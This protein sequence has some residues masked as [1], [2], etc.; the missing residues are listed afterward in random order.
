MGQKIK[1]ILIMEIG[2][3]I[4][5]TWIYYFRNDIRTFKKYFHGNC[6]FVKKLDTK[7]YRLLAKCKHPKD[8]SI[9][10]LNEEIPNNAMKKKKDSYNYECWE[11][12]KNKQS[13]GR[14]STN[15]EGHKQN[16]TN[17]SCMFETKKYSHVE[18]KIFK[19]LDYMDFLKNSRTISNKTYRKLVRK[20]YG[21]RIVLP[22]LLFLLLLT[23]FVED[24]S[25]GY[26]F[27]S[28]GGS[29]GLIG[30]TEYLKTLTKQNIEW[31]NTFLEW[32]KDKL[33][34]LS[35]CSNLNT[36]TH[37]AC[38]LGPIFGILIYFIPF[39]ILGVTFVLAIFYYHK[40]VKKYEKIKYR[41]R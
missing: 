15:Q 30:L 16:I 18:K 40:K 17:K 24:L 21:L 14:S 29:W 27:E 10:G 7:T 22:L 11:K 34:W 35:A 6:N 1:F 12:S 37:K 19:E 32:L 20:K 8:T 5:L 41:K 26:A 33:P 25:V 3:F 31:L 4:L 9:V 13:N 38:F 23:V 28:D 36:G 2:A 39:L